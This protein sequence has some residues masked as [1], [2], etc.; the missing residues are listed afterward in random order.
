MIVVQI[1]HTVRPEHV[2]RYVEA[3]LANAAATRQEP[4]NVR[5]DLLADASDPCTFQLYEVYVD[6]PA[7]AAHLASAHFEAWKAAVK[8][9][10]AGASIAR[11]EAVHV[12]QG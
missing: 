10:F 12:P 7:Q 6:R 2:D 11:F 4:G 8:G 1:T 5:F 3:T 9:V